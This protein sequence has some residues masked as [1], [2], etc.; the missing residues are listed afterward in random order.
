MDY[1]SSKKFYQLAIRTKQI[2]SDGL[3]TLNAH[4]WSNRDIRDIRRTDVISLRD[5][6]YDMPGKCRI[7]LV[8]ASNVLGFCYDHGLVEYNVAAGMKDLPPTKGYERWTDAEMDQFLDTAP[9]H[10]K[11]VMML[12]LY[13]GQRRS[14]LVKM[15]WSDLDVSG[16]RWWMHVVQKKTGTELWI[17]IHP[18]LRAHLEAMYLVRRKGPDYILLNFFGQRWIADNM[19]CAVKRHNA[20]IGLREKALHGV[21]KTTAS[22]LAE[23]GCDALQI[24][25]ITGHLSLKE[26][27]RYTF[28][29]E[30]KR[31]AERAMNKWENHDGNDAGNPA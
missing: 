29:A 17:P 14:D 24:G 15:R 21:R 30:R 9:P 2:Y 25:A 20:K 4:G 27:Q 11:N 12:A 13:T 28:D 8:M 23:M 31:L 5:Q 7:A 6:L 26:L 1:M 3:N 16:K 18:K 10:L 19:R 22:I